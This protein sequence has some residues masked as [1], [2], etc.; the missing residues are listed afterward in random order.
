MRMAP[1][2]M[3]GIDLTEK[4]DS[5]FPTTCWEF[6]HCRRFRGVALDKV[7]HYEN[8]V[9]IGSIVTKAPNVCWVP[10]R[11]AVYSFKVREI[12]ALA[13]AT[14][15]RPF[16]RQPRIAQSGSIFVST[17]L[18]FSLWLV[19]GPVQSSSSS[20]LSAARVAPGPV[21]R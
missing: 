17:F 5:S 6:Q 16:G 11:F 3:V 2:R 21:V 1:M 13:A 19:C 12:V 7:R 8:G 15:P 18:R 9:F 20:P 14:R 10:T 4:Q